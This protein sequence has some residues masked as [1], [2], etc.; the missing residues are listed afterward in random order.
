MYTSLNYIT[1]HYPSCQPVCVSVC[2]CVYEWGFLCICVHVCMCVCVSVAVCCCWLEGEVCLGKCVNSK[3]SESSFDTSTNEHGVQQESWH[4]L[5]A[6]L[7]DHSVGKHHT[8]PWLYLI[9]LAQVRRLICMKESGLVRCISIDQCHKKFDFR[10][11]F[12]GF[13]AIEKLWFKGAALKDWIQIIQ[14]FFWIHPCFYSLLYIHIGIHVSDVW[15]S[16]TRCLHV[17]WLADRTRS[18]TN[19]KKRALELNLLKV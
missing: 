1:R 19:L 16:R 7:S 11:W 10:R 12:D 3:N 5:S 4:R 17:A 14:A 8:V 13:Q 6:C 2:E 15:C 18:Y 9:W